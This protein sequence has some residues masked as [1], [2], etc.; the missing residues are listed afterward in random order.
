MAEC[1]YMFPSGELCPARANRQGY[2]KE[3]D[4]TD[5]KKRARDEQDKRRERAEKE[6]EREDRLQQRRDIFAQQLKEAVLEINDLESLRRV[7]LKVLH[8]LITG[9]IEDPRVG[10]PVVQLLKHQETLLEKTAKKDQALTQNQREVIVQL[11]LQMP[12]EKQLELLG[13]LAGGVKKLATQVK[14]DAYIDAESVKEI[15]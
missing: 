14:T 2:C 5:A 1:I 12:P 3:H 10:S 6:A 8:A 7:E 15:E 9:E 4:P 11:A 13:D